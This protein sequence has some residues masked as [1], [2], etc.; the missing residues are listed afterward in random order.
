VRGVGSVLF[1][2]RGWPSYYNIYLSMKNVDVRG[3]QICVKKAGG[4]LQR[5]RTKRV[6][7][8]SIA[9]RDEGLKVG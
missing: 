1:Y 7:T 8:S 5:L 3:V 6:L 4:K 9:M 2:E